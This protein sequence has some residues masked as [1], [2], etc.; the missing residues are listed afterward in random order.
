MKPRKRFIP[1]VRIFLSDANQLHAQFKMLVTFN[2]LNSLE[3]H[4]NVS[5]STTF[6]HIE[7]Y[8]G[9]L[10]YVPTIWR[11]IGSYE[12]KEGVVSL[13]YKNISEVYL[14]PS[15]STAEDSL[16]EKEP[17]HLST[18]LNGWFQRFQIWFV[19]N[20]FYGSNLVAGRNDGSQRDNVYM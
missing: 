16:F 9:S 10:T 12:S 18:N 15:L 6:T 11:M 4:H 1:S 17:W 7:L 14:V 13:S 2:S 3:L 19:P 8:R 5:C 20:D